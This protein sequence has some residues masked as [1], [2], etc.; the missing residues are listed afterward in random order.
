MYLFY[1]HPV[2]YIIFTLNNNHFAHLSVAFGWHFL[3][4]LIQRHLPNLRLSAQTA[5]GLQW[6]L[7]KSV[8][9][10]K[11]PPPEVITVDV[12]MVSSRRPR[13]LLSA[14]SYIPELSVLLDC[15]KYHPAPF[16]RPP[17]T[18]SF[19]NSMLFDL[20]R[21]PSD[22]EVKHIEIYVTRLE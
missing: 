8:D 13:R 19:R 6:T 15:I 10:H 22:P 16:K 17:F 18:T 2:Y 21:N 5:T 1:N 11:K 20:R 7:D 12:R 3:F 4:P 14:L 9:Y